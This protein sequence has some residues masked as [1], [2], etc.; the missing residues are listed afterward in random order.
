MIAD[1]A[2]KNSR[3]ENQAAAPLPVLGIPGFEYADL[4]SPYGLRRLYDTWLAELQDGDAALGER[5]LAYRDAGGQNL[6]P[7][8]LSNLLTDVAPWV[9]R[10]VARLFPQAKAR[11]DEIAAATREDLHIFRFKDEFIKR[12]ASKRLT[13]SELEAKN[14]VLAAGEALAD[15]LGISREGRSD[16]LTLAKAVCKLLDREAEL[17]KRGPDDAELV[18]VRQDLDV[19]GDW[20]MARKDELLHEHHFLSLHFPHHLDP[21][22]LVPLRRPDPKLPELF[23]GHTHK[24]RHRDGFKLTDRRASP[25]EVLDQVDY[26]MYCHDRDKDSC[27]K[28]MRDKQGA[29]KQNAIGVPIPGCPLHEKISEMHTLRRQGDSLGALVLITVDNPMCPGTGH[30]ICNDCM[31][32]CIYQKQEPVNIPQIETAALTDVLGLPYGVEIYGLLTRWNPLNVRR[33]YPLPYNGRNVLV[34]GLGPAGYTLCHHLSRE[35]F[36]VIG[37]DGLKLEPPPAKIVGD[38]RRGVLPQP[39]RDWHAL[40]TEL[41]ERILTGFGG[42]SEYGI[43]VRWDKNFLTLLYLTLSRS[44]NVRLYGGVRFGG[45]LTLEDAWELGIDHVAVAAGSGKPTLIEIENNLCRGIRKASDFLMALQLTGAFKKDSLANLQIRLPAVVIGGGLTAI[46]TATELLAYYIVQVE[47]TLERWEQLLARPGSGRG[48]ARTALPIEGGQ[49]MTA[50]EE[51]RLLR[52][53][54]AEEREIL[55]EQLAHGREVRAERQAAKAAGRAPNFNR[56]LDSWGGVSLVYRKNLIDSPAYRLNHEEVEKSLEEGVR[57]IERMAPKAALLD[58]Y[59]ALRAMTFE[60]QSQDAATGKWHS[61]GELIEL[62]ARTVCVAA[63][64][65]P[66]T[67]YEK[68]HPGTFQL[69]KGGYFAPH[70][71]EINGYGASRTLRTVPSPDGFFTSYE[72]SGHVVSYY[73]DNHPRY[74]GSVVKAMASAKDGYPHVAAL[75]IDEVAAAA[76]ETA[77]KSPSAGQKERDRRWQKFIDFLDDQLIATVI[78]VERLTPTIVD[79][80]VRAPLAARKFRPGQFYRLQNLE[81]SSQ[82]VAGIRMA[83]EGLALTGAASHPEAGILSLIVL[84]MGGS[85]RLCP[86]L[87]PGEPVVVMGPTGTPTEI[88]QN[89]DVCL[90]GGGLGNAVL[91]SIAR[92]LKENGCRVLYFAG[93][94]KPDDVYKQDEIEASTDQVIWSCD[95]PVPPGGKLHPRR[96]Q[97]RLFIGNIVEA[98]AA[99]AR[100]ELSSASPGIDLRNVTRLIAIGSDRMMAAVARARHGVLR[101]FLNPQH[102]GIASINSPMQCMMKEVC[103]QCLQKHVDPI[104][105]KETVVFTC[106]NQDQD[107]DRVD[108]SN[109]AERLRQNSTQEKLVSLWLDRSLPPSPV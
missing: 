65:S 19:I 27:S 18:A 109:L 53:F 76:A 92:A 88:P 5:Y 73:G 20:V 101:P 87:K 89:E 62:L 38:L 33:P 81:S 67:I 1:S 6:G 102:V 29:V 56:L 58:Q 47:K 14:A 80:V 91:F 48:E 74:A 8:E 50:L 36:G 93:Y 78:K 55:L 96:P 23:V 40:E 59:G 34:V 46:D 70:R 51:A 39:V 97:D 7:V 11:L 49:D 72:Q 24:L 82:S 16:E 95:A 57:Y 104:T 4:F 85:S 106:F 15:R 22:H 32:A 105:G 25:R 9:S 100:G 71:V 17:K 64:T 13:P 43:T 52:A 28:G 77:E 107:L 79:V 26:C 99:Y 63:G 2:S 68:E 75:Y 60:R 69:G 86:T 31:K 108:W 44:A 83:M 98:M 45:T 37:V 3:P 84:E 41:D 42:V 103:A 35:G 54:D 21:Q 94:K 66:N 10:F 30:R 12:R 90:V 61:T